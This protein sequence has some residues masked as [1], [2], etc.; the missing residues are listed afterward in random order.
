MH[1]TTMGFNASPALVKP[2]RQTV[3]DLPP[4]AI[5]PAQQF[6]SRPEIDI[7]DLS[8]LSDTIEVEGMIGEVKRAS[9]SVDILHTYLG[10]LKISL[11]DGV[12]EIELFDRERSNAKRLQR[13]FSIAIPRGYDPNRAWSLIV[14]DLES[15]DEGTLITWSIRFY[16]E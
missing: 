11:F 9:V 15:G 7:T 5:V 6:E 13:S 2:A 16:A 8:R 10:D 1:C 3:R 4:P 12:Q 14:S